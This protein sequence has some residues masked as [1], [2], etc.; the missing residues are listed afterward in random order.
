VGAVA[1]YTFTNVTANHTIVASFT[2]D[3]Y[4]ITATAGANGSIDPSGSVTV[5]YGADQSFDITPNPG[6][7]V[8]DVLVDGSSV[9][10][11][12]TTPSRPSP[13]TTRSAPRS[14]PRPTR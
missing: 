6:F 12:P 9:G 5:N 1:S 7:N 10:G 13:R 11:W 4:S 3:T 14:W 8:A 2:I